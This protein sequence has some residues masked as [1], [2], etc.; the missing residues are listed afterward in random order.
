MKK[1]ILFTGGT[2]LLALNWANLICDKFDVVLGFHERQIT[3]NKVNFFIISLESEEEFLKC[4]DRIKPDCIIHTAGM[5]NVDNCEIFP[6]LANKINFEG[7]KI[8]SNVCVKNNIDLIFISTDHLFDGTIPNVSEDHIKNPLN[9]YGYTKSSGEDYII[10]NN[11]NALIIRTNFFGWGTS[12]R[13]SFS[14]FIIYNLRNGKNIILFNDVFYTP[15]VI[16]CL[17]ELVM[18]LYLKNAKGVFNIVGDERL[19]KLDFGLKLAACF[20]LNSNLILE[21]SISDNF[22][23]VKRPNDLSL[24]NSKVKYFL[25]TEIK[26]LNDQI[27]ILCLNEST[28]FL[29]LSSSLL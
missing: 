13:K 18:N 22:N 9:C 27:L 7:A 19:S 23:L 11:P 24:S 6:E 28:K 14:D 1:K 8:V 25:N 5:T 12:Y 20:E 26:N 16:D 2:G 29:N 4:V 10:L 17:V 15:I 21:G 3:L